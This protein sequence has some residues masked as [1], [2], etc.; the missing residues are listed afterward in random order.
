MPT[1]IYDSSLLT[2]KRQQQAVYSFNNNIATAATSNIYANIKLK[3]INAN[4]SQEIIVDKNLGCSVC[5]ASSNG[6]DSMGRT[7]DGCGCGNSH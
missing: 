7:R 3:G 5:N 1:A 2:L 4:P 6:Y